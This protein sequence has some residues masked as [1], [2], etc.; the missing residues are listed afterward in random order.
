MGKVRF[1][2]S[3]IAMLA[4]SYGILEI[5]EF[6]DKNIISRDTLLKENLNKFL[7]GKNPFQN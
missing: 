1:I 4:L 2:S 3:V 5:Q 7:N 6:L